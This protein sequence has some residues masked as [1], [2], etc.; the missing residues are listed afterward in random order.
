MI[1]C[2]KRAQRVVIR[3]ASDTCLGHDCRDVAARGD[4]EGGVRR[5]DAGGRDRN[6]TYARDLVWIALFYENEFARSKAQ[7]NG[8]TGSYHI[9]R[10]VVRLCQHC[11]AVGANLVG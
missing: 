3:W 8:R 5:V 10:N 7:I 6:A 4:I 1:P 2:T 11:Y 9:K